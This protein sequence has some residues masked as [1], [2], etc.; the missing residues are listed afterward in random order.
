MF[1]AFAPASDFWTPVFAILS[2]AT[3]TI[4]N[5]VALQQTQ[6]VRL[7]AYS[8]IA[9]A[10]YML[11]PFAL[12]GATPQIDQKAFQAVELYILIYGVMNLGAFAVLTAMA[13]ESPTLLMEDFSGLIRRSP[14]LAGSMTVF[15]ISLAGI[16]PTAGF[17]AKVFVFS[18][19]VQEGGR[20][21]GPWLAAI[22][23]INSVIS[24]GYYI[25]LTRQMI[26]V[27]G[28]LRPFRSPALIT[29]MV[30]VA[31]LTVFAVFIYPDILARFPQGATL[32]GTP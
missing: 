14:V 13:R 11:L 25:G 24:V 5:L 28:D 2:I 17:F 20:A 15:L 26:F 23:V 31:A 22:M 7:F 6:V 32:V 10:G 9:Q 12:V 19:A 4:G 30:L 27:E 16:P 8:S 1:V 21:V 29:G 18:A 3:M